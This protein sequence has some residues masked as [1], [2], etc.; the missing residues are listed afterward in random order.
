LECIRFCTPLLACRHPAIME[1]LGQEYP[2]YFSSQQEA[3]AKIS[4]LSLIR[5][6]HEYLRG[7]ISPYPLQY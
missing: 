7:V 6:T 5:K 2:F 3:N 4:D 1:Y